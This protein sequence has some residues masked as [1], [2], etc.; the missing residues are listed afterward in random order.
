MPMNSD[1]QNLIK[2]AV[3]GHPVNQSKSPL[4]HNYWLRKYSILGVYEAID[5][6]PDNF[7]SEVRALIE[8]GYK[9]FNFTIPHKDAGM[10]LCDEIDD[11]A[12]KIGAVN[13]AYIANGKIHG[14]NTDAFGFVHNIRTCVPE[15]R[16]ST[17]PAVVL[18]AGGAAKAVV[19]GLVEEGAPEIRIF[20]RTKNKAEDIA[21]KFAGGAVAAYDW[22]DRGIHLEDAAFVVNTTSLGMKGQP[23]LF[24]NLQDLNEKAVVNDLVYTPLQTSLLRNAKLNGNPT[25]TGVGMLVHQARPGFKH[26]FDVMPKIDNEMRELLGL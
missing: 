8:K 17:G 13:T 3:I 16:F 9:G 26:W 7:E 19:H 25:V 21:K 5:I 15:F 18:G 11:V 12:E 14:T 4:I 6:E 23:D 1:T 24:M 20:N 22:D 10:K 2:A